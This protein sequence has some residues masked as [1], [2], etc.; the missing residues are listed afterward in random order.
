MSSLQCYF[1]TRLT[2]VL[3]LILGN[4][5]A[6]T[7]GSCI[8]Y[9]SAI[10]NPKAIVNAVVEEKC[11]ALHGVPTHFL[12]VLDEVEKRRKAGES[13][14]T[15]SLRRVHLPFLF[16]W[17]FLTGKQYRTGIAAGSPVPIDLMKSLIDKLGLTELTNAYGM[18]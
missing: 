13:L 8:V 18:S 3:R 12:G 7:H 4:L 5:A 9:A 16:S 11:T 6:W 2:Y 14:D 10:Y 15:S 1:Y 17:V